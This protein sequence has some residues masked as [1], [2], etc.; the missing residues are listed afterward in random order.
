MKPGGGP[1]TQGRKA[2]ARAGAR[3]AAAGVAGTGEKARCS[4]GKAG[5]LASGP[6]AA[7][8]GQKGSGRVGTGGPSG[9]AAAPP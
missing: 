7:Q 9:V 5:A 1:R 6:D 8:N 2:L 4:P 3:M